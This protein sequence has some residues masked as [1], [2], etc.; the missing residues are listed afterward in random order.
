MNYDEYS[1]ADFATDGFF[2]RWVKNPDDESEWFWTSFM[3]ENPAS[4]DEIAAA[5][6]L[7]CL[8]D[9]PVSRLDDEELSSMRSGLVM[10]LLARRGEHR[11]SKGAPRRRIRRV[12]TV[13]LRVAAAAVIVP[14]VSC[15]LYF[16]VPTSRDVISQAA[17]DGVG[18]EKRVNQ[19]SD[20]SLFF[21]ADGTKVWLNTGTRISYA[22]DFGKGKTRDV[23]LDGE[24][25]FDVVHRANQPF[26]VHTSSIRIKV[27][28]TSFNV[29]S[30]SASKTI[31][32]TLVRGK[33]RIESNVKGRRPGGIELM[34][35]QRAVFDKESKVINI[36]QVKAEQ[37]ASWKQDRLVFDG[38]SIDQVI[39]QLEKWFDVTIH[40]E[41]RGHLGCRLSAVIENESLEEV[42]KMIETTHD[43][44]YTIH[45]DDVFLE[46]KFCDSGENE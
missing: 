32:T 36:R 38:E 41:N 23:Y 10:A 40:V 6:K 16:F 11:Y 14:L 12:S 45:G 22:R 26:I 8:F 37:S 44:H 43:V 3:E 31:E 9:S 27:L 4:R 15:L 2:I 5:R 24:A 33:V 42:L 21:L 28:G 25:F 1:A 35:N 20:K 17:G 34:P 13:W 19:E 29:K 18:L 39:Q 7:V 46:G 30:Y